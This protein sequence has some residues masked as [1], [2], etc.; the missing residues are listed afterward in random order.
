MVNGRLHVDD[1]GEPSALRVL[2]HLLSHLQCASVQF[3][4][5]S[6]I[7]LMLHLS[8]TWSSK[9]VFSPVVQISILLLTESLHVS[10]YEVLLNSCH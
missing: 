2:S 8:G 5:I 3:L 7:L 9:S 1:A 4:H 6:T 10:V